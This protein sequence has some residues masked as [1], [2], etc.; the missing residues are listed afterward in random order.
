MKLRG[1]RPHK[2]LGSKFCGHSPQNRYRGPSGFE[3]SVLWGLRPRSF[4][5]AKTLKIKKF[6]KISKFLS[7]AK[8]F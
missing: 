8:I 2:T 7:R 6:A 5:S 1:L 3:P 4:I